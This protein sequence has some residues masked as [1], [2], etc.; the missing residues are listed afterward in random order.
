[1]T[2]PAALRAGQWAFIG[3]M[4]A[5]MALFIELGSWQ[6]I[7]LAEKEALIATVTERLHAAPLPLPASGDWGD[8]EGFLYRPVSVEGRWLRDKTVLVFTSLM[9][10][11]A[12]PAS[13][14]GYWVLVPFER[15]DRSVVFVNRGFVPEAEAGRF[16]A[17]EGITE[18]PVT[19]TGIALK[20]EAVGS[21]TPA[22][23]TAEGIDWVTN[24][25]RLAA[26]AG[27]DPATVAPFTIDLPQN[28]AGGLPQGGE[29]V[30]DFPN[31][32]LGYL[33]TW[34]GFAALVPPLL[35]FW[36]RRQRRGPE[37]PA[38]KP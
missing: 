7:R 4:L 5:L 31:N 8:V 15:A 20:P 19:V 16:R 34:F 23:D 9:E 27:L 3:L 25:A 17:G 26:L 24:P 33:L 35:W 32:H 10:P 2:N 1:M 22:P 13:G 12:G 37:T 30:L 14:P 6:T 29:T 18:E 36:L 21:F 28:P 38:Q 11:K